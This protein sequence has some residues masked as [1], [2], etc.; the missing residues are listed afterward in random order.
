MTG[1]SSAVGF[2]GDRQQAKQQNRIAS[3]N[4]EQAELAYQSEQAA[5]NG[6]N[7]RNGTIF[8]EE[9]TDNVLE[10]ARATGAARASS[11]GRGSTGQSYN[12]IIR[13]YT[14]ARDTVLGR[15][16]NNHIQNIANSDNDKVASYNKLK[17][18]YASNQNVAKPSLLQAAMPSISQGFMNKYKLGE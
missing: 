13:G 12:E 8:R 10:A 11:A 18:R 2:L 17:S 1:F 9:A 3:E 14:T 5:I 15:Q 7:V 6:N 16:K 4:R